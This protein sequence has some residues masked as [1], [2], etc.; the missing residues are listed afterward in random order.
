MSP[1]CS[2]E[3]ETSVICYPA[4]KAFTVSIEGDSR[5]IT[6]K[7]PAQDSSF[8][9]AM[10]EQEGEYPIRNA[11]LGGFTV[12]DIGAGYGE[13][14]ALC[15]LLGASRILCFEP[16]RHVFRYLRGNLQGL[17]NI[18][19]Y[20]KGVYSEEGTTVLFSRRRGTAS[21]S[22]SEVQYDPEHPSAQDRDQQVVEIT[23]IS[24]ALSD[25]S[26]SFV[27]KIDA[28]GVE[29]AILEAA[30]ELDLLSNCELLFVEYHA[31]LGHLPLK[32]EQAGFCFEIQEKDSRMGLINAKRVA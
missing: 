16:N 31:G 10:I 11:K 13:F 29:Y 20:Q 24:K 21:G 32:L 14:S 19:L 22:I 1:I 8:D 9:V 30:C 23:S 28:E 6:I 27:L 25:I 26:G 3:R 17:P 7:G 15:F 12:V 18:E 5:A 2:R 4:E